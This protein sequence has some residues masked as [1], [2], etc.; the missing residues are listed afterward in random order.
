MSTKL[1]RLTELA[2]EEPK[3]QFLL[4]RS[5]D[6]ARGDVCGNSKSTKGSQ[7]RDGR[8]HASGVPKGRREKDPRALSEA[9]RREVPSPTA[10]QGLHTEGE[11]EAEADLD[12]ALEAKM[13]Q[14]AMVEVMN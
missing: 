12:S 3:R 9:Q 14:K 11:R 4:D 8:R 13:V 7:R 6:H 1:D 5:L 2:K 10:P